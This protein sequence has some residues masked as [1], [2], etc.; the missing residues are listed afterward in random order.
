M[1]A[2]PR[3]ADQP[4]LAARIEHAGIGLRDSFHRPD[5]N[6]LRA[7]IRRVLSDGSFRQRMTEVRAAVVAAG[8]AR[9]AADVAERVLVERRP[10]TRDMMRQS[11]GLPRIELT[12][13]Q[14]GFH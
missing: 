9:Y 1:V 4:A 7:K 11:A 12:N 2:L 13:G 8:G 3:G 5:A 14:A 10:I 6:R